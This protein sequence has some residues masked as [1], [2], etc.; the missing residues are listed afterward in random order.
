MESWKVIIY[1]R[2]SHCST[3]DIAHMI[4][5]TCSP[6]SPFLMYIEKIIGEPGGEAIYIYIYI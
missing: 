5:C 4:S 3:D 2:F 1:D 6:P